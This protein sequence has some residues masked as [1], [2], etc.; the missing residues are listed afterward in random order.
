MAD[1]IIREIE[2]ALG[3][4]ESVKNDSFAEGMDGLLEYPLYTRP[5]EFEGEKVP[6]VLKSGDHKK[7]AQWRKEK[8]LE[9]TKNRRPDLLK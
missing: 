7:I 3:N 6:E 9:R 2:G 4:F 1:S 5:E 8:A